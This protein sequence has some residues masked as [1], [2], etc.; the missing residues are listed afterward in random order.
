MGLEHFAAD[1]EG[2]L[3]DYPRFLRQAEFPACQVAAKAVC[4]YQRQHRPK[5]A[6]SKNCEITPEDCK[7]AI[8]V[9]LRDG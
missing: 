6:E 2:E 5:E 7:T 9:S 8:S 3:I 4:P 1:S